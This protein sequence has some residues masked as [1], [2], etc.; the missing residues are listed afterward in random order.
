MSKTKR[1][2]KS[3]G[4]GRD[5]RITRSRIQA[6]LKT[7]EGKAR[8]MIMDMARGGIDCRGMDLA[9]RNMILTA[10]Y[11][12]AMHEAHRM[13]GDELPALDGPQYQRC[14]MVGI[15]CRVLKARL[16]RDETMFLHCLYLVIV[17]PDGSAREVV[18][19]LV[20]D[21]MAYA[22]GRIGAELFAA[23]WRIK[24]VGAQRAAPEDTGE[25]DG[26]GQ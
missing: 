16:T 4:R 9:G 10:A 11:N 20:D 3:S 14:W 6:W 22:A 12:R 17:E 26:H 19:V 24:D 23:N 5:R 15:L 21:I 1:Q 2:H 25:T 7:P 18:Q 13:E 8:L